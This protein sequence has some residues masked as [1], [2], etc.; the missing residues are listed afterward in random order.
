M[1]FTWLTNLSLSDLRD[2][3][4]RLPDH[5]VVLYLTMF[6][7]ATGASF[8]PRQAL[9]LFAP[10]SRAPI[11]GSLRHLPWEWDCWRLDG[12]I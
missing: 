12:D 1:S 6:Q 3:L 7:D 9:A 10:A 11:Y 8:I 2:E 5:T 4:S